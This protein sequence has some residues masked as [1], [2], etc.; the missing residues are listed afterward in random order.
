MNHVEFDFSDINIYLTDAKLI[1]RRHKAP[2]L[3]II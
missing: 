1:K 3:L 2:V